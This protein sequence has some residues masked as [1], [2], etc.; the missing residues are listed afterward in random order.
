MFILFNF[1]VKSIKGGRQTKSGSLNSGS[2]TI[3]TL[4]DIKGLILILPMFFYK[5]GL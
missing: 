4:S 2:I 5:N 3:S 1:I